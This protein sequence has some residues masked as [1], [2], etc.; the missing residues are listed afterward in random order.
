MSGARHAA[1]V[2]AGLTALLAFSSAATA[3]D[4]CPGGTAIPSRA[5]TGR[6]AAGTLCDVNAQ[7]RAYGLAPLRWNR[8]LARAARR[9][10]WDMGARNYFGHVNSAG[11]DLRARIAATGYASR[12]SSWAIGENIAWGSGSLSTP[13][14][15]IAAWLASPDHRQNMLSPSFR[16]VGIGVVKGSPIAGNA[17]GAIFVADFGVR[18]R[19]ARL[20]AP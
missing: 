18:H 5:S 8:R 14:E 4:G 7:R 1:A 12:V 20:A 13:D 11:Q 17:S 6:A 10:A 3:Q 15:I 16:E 19:R 9:M 2:A